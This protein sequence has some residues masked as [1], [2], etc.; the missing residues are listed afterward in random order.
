[1][2]LSIYA[3]KLFAWFK[4]YKITPGQYYYHLSYHPKAVPHGLFRKAFDELL[5]EYG[6]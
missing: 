5:A 4:R 6:I 2:A 3:E 1:M